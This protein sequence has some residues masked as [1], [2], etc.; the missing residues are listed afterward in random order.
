MYSPRLRD[1]QIHQL[2]KLVKIRKRPMTKVL[3]KIVDEYF[4]SHRQELSV[5]AAVVTSIE[6]K[7]AV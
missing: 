2:W 5:T 3:W 4:Q 6:I 7:E 1:D